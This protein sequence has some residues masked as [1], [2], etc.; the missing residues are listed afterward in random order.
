MATATE[1][2]MTPQQVH[3]CFPKTNLRIKIRVAWQNWKVRKTGRAVR[4][5]SEQ[6]RKDPG[7]RQTWHANIA[8]PI[9]DATRPTCSCTPLGPS[10]HQHHPSC[11]VYQAG[12]RSDVHGMPIAQANHIADKLMKHLFN[13]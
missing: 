7:F 4:H 6:L 13:A 3:A 9:Y 11:P 1:T 10:E 2:P 5:L 8:M 12:E